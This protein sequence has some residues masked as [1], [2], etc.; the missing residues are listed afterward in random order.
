MSKKYDTNEIANKIVKL[1][2]DEE[3]TFDDASYVLSKAQEKIRYE[4]TIKLAGNKDK[5]Q[6]KLVKNMK[7]LLLKLLTY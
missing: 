1:I 7:I 4:A 3:L 6:W 2:A 5:T